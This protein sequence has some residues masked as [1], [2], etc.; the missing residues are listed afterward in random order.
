V[1]AVALAA[2][3]FFPSTPDGPIAPIGPRSDTGRGQRLFFFG[4]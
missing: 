4:P 1:P 3:P 2:A